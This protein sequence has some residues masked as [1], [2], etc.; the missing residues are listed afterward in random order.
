MKKRPTLLN[1]KNEPAKKTIYSNC[2]F[3]AFRNIKFLGSSKILVA[4]SRNAS[5]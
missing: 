4:A 3:I 5:N 2:I 1:K